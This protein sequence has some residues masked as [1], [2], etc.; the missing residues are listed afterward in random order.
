MKIY[1]VIWRNYS[2]DDISIVA[3]TVNKE[4]AEYYAKTYDADIEEYDDAQELPKTP[5]WNYF[6]YSDSCY[7]F[8][9]YKSPTEE[10]IDGDMVCVRAEDEAHARKKAQDMIARYKAEKEGIT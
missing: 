10:S 8:E 3:L 1:A 6:A 9:P 4:C 2:D 5:M 7:L